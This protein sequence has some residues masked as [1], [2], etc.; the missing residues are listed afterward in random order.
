MPP[1]QT[2]DFGKRRSAAKQENQ[3][4]LGSPSAAAS[5]ESSVVWAG[6]DAADVES[7]SPKKAATHARSGGRARR[8]CDRRPP[9]S[10]PHHR[11]TRLQPDLHIG[12]TTVK[13]HITH[14]LQK[15]DLRDRV[16]LIV[17]AYR[18][19]IVEAGSDR[20]TGAYP[21]IGAWVGW[22]SCLG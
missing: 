4:P 3:S 1:P 12:D 10:R 13:T 15:L 18:T 17:P 16:Q 9:Q 19:G 7:K 22:Q 14:I 8:R 6:I 21:V 11:P 2:N 5:H 20:R